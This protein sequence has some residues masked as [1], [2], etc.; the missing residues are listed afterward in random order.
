ME[1][2]LPCILRLRITL[3]AVHTTDDLRRLRDALVECIDLK[4]IQVFNRSCRPK[5]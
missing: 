2:Y 4:E 1:F 5:L 3:S